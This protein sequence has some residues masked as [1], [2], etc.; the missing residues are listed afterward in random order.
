MKQLRRPQLLSNLY[1]DMRDRRMLLPA[2]A[3]VAALIVVPLMLNRSS[4]GTA[5]PPTTEST[6]HADQASATEPA[7]VTQQLGVTDY[8][9]RL[10]QFQSKNPFRRHYTALP[11]NAKL[12]TT[13]SGGTSTSATSA[14]SATTTSAT[15][16][17]SPSPSTTSLSGGSSS[18]SAPP[19][20]APTGSGSGESGGGTSD[21]PASPGWF[22]F[23]VSVAVG[24]AGHLTE[25]KS[26][27]RLTFLPGDNR[28]LVAFIGVT[29]DA[30]RAIFSVSHDVSSVRGDG[31]CTPR[32]GSC[33]FLEL[34]PGDKASLAYAPEGNRAYNLKLRGIKLVPVSKPHGSAA[35]K[36]GSHLVLGPDG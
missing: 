25:Q 34:Q 2:I 23:R 9:K 24:P 29:E 7:V 14:T 21:K 36:R 11:K 32:R 22:S 26:V 6:P 10:D 27:K 12:S 4:S 20:T 3:L 33:S 8:R 17:S 18:F 16:V 28:P 31:H 5:P 30:K 15:G 13:S 35:G 1:R 19:S